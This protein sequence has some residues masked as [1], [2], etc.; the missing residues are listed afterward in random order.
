MDICI[1]LSYL[2]TCCTQVAKVAR[3]AACQTRPVDMVTDVIVKA[4]TT[5]VVTVLSKRLIVASYQDNTVYRQ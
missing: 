3:I 2:L 5:G 1:V 4:M